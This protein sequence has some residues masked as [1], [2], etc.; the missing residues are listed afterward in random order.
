MVVDVHKVNYKMFTIISVYLPRPLH[1]FLRIVLLEGS[2]LGE[3]GNISHN[4]T[5]KLT[6]HSLIRNGAPSVMLVKIENV[7]P[8]ML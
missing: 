2:N 1:I 7:C 5:P 8:N 4:S 3:F 6:P